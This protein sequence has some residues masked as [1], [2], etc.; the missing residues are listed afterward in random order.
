MEKR[1]HGILFTDA[2]LVAVGLLDLVTTLV[3]FRN[4]CAVEANPVMAALL[5]AG[6]PTFVTVKVFTL[7]AYVAAV[8]WY[9]HRNATF[10][11]T[12]SNFTL[13]AYLFLYATS[14]WCVNH[15]FFLG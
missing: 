4:G 10:C 7:V 2:A 13:F 8:A 14:F 9:R 6:L 3:W 12:V 1:A 15:A 5:H 11:R